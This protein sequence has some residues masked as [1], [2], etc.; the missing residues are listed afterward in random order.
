[1]NA[2]SDTIIAQCTPAGNGAIALI[3]LSGNN[4]FVVA[5][6]ISRLVS[7]NTIATCATHTIQYGWVV[8]STGI[9]IDQV[10]FLLMRAP[11]TFTGED[12]IEITCHNNPFIIEAIIE[13]ALLQGARLA[14]E[15]EFS[16]QAFLNGKIDLIQAEAINELIHAST[17]MALRQ[18]LSQL[19]GSFSQWI[20]VLE[21]QLLKALALSEASFEFLDE[22]MEFG[23]QIQEIIQYLMHSIATI[24][25]TFN[26]QQQ[27]R[28]GI[29]IT[30][31]GAV[32]AGKSSLFNTLLKQNRAIVTDIPGTTRDSIEA[33]MYKNGTY[34]TLIDT[35][36]LRHTDDIIEKEGIERSFA[37]ASQADI[38]IVVYDGSRAM[39]GEEYE[40]YQSLIKAYSH[41]I[42]VLHNKADIP[43]SN[44][45]PLGY[46][47]IIYV[48]S[49]THYNISR[50]ETALEHTIEKLYK[51]I[52]SPFLLN[53]RQHKLL[54][55][56]EKKLSIIQEMLMH[57]ISY[58]LLPYHLTEAL[59]DL[60]ELSGKT[61]TQKG[62]DA[63]FREFCIGK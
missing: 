7:E 10:L 33:G 5:T 16:Q 50:L 51:T 57:T 45:N 53:Q 38:I 6:A 32:N 41:N 2:S 37:Q 46:K 62:M 13:Q 36:G 31:I 9:I 26:Q 35:A 23:P 25:A 8:S 54:V 14:K 18:S 52:E 3:R 34:I 1:M 20:T 27:I 55:S 22:E 29:R 59:Q 48:S 24:K 44:A 30:L 40:T 63:I 43:Y 15:G 11:R 60:S 47:D 21:K 12:T 56:L 4:A 58:E 42:I 19:E 49:A 39:T 28:Q 17:Q 61:I